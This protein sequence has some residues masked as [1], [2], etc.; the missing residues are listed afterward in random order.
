ML[1]NECIFKKETN[2]NKKHIFLK[3]K[4]NLQ[5]GYFMETQNHQG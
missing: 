2:N 1:V 4:I 5:I 3:L